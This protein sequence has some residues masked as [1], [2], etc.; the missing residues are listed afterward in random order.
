MELILTA[1]EAV[2][3]T[4]GSLVAA[5]ILCL[6]FWYGFK[7]VAH[8]ECTAAAVFLLVALAVL[9]VLPDSP[10]LKMTLMFAVIAAVPLWFTGRMW[11]KQHRLDPPG[12]RV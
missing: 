4:V 2:I 11:R 3:A 6:S 1:A 10:F 7:S 12:A 9:G 5:A 8:P